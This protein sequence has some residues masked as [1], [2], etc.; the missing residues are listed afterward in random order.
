MVERVDKKVG[1]LA[2]KAQGWFYLQHTLS[3]GGGLHDDSQFSESLTDRQSLFGGRLE[4]YPVP[5]ELETE[6][7]PG[8]VDS[9]H[10]WVA[11]TQFLQPG[12]EIGTGVARVALQLLVTDHVEHGHP[13][14]GTDR[15]AT[16]RRE[17]VAL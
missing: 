17:E 11:G 6:I 7:Q 8:S 10:E 15:A 1:T 5:Y 14:H 13:D 12:L 9:T 16:G 4:R 3:V 2:G